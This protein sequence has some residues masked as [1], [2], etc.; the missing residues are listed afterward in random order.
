MNHPPNVIAR[1]PALY[2]TY[3]P[4]FNYSENAFVSKTA[5]LSRRR[6]DFAC[7][8]RG[9][10]LVALLGTSFLLVQSL[11]FHSPLLRSV[12]IVGKTMLKWTLVAL[13]A[14]YLVLVLPTWEPAQ[15]FED[16]D[17]LRERVYDLFRR[18]SI[19]TL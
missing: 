17:L 16:L 9:A 4:E 11:A 14:V 2:G 15:P 7:G 5:G 10:A 13:P 18:K 19:L 12:P 1:H 8:S 3:D 6:S